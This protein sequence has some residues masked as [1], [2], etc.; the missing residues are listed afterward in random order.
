MYTRNCE[1]VVIHQHSRELRITG[2][3]YRGRW[4]KNKHDGKQPI[5]K[6][7]VM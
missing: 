5:I 6:A 7:N 4:I 3:V 1:C 2:D